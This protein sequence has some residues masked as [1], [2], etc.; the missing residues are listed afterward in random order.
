MYRRGAQ[1]ARR[2]AEAETRVR[3]PEQTYRVS[4]RFTGTPDR[5]TPSFTSDPPLPTVDVLSL[6]FGEATGTENLQEKA[7]HRPV[8]KMGDDGHHR[9]LDAVVQSEQTRRLEDCDASRTG[10][11]SGLPI[12]L[13]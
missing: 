8:R 7:E 4:L 1:L 3:V 2:R 9:R 10:T 5:I 11:V 6:L 13:R 12:T